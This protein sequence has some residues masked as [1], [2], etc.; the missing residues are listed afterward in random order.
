ME[1]PLTQ[2]LMAEP[3][4]L[5][6]GAVLPNR[7]VKAA[8]SE[9]LAD[10]YNN[11]DERLIRLYTAW[12]HG[13]SG[14]ILSGNVMVDRDHVNR[15]GSMVI[16]GQ[17]DRESYIRLAEAGR[18]GGN[19]FW[20]QIVHNGR[21]T[22]SSINS[23]PLAPS[24]IP[25]DLGDHFC[26]P[27]AMTEEEILDAIARF[28][29]ASKVAKETGF[30]GVQLHGAHGYLVS[31]F[32]SP[33]TNK[34]TDRWGGSLENRSRFCIETLRAMRE[35]VGP[36]FP[37]AIKL[38][39]ADFQR[40]GF[41]HDES[42]AVVAML[43]EES[44][45]LLEIS[46]GT[47]EQMGMFGEDDEAAPVV[48]ESTREREAY[49]LE[50]AESIRKIATMPLMV[51]GGFRTRGGIEEALATGATDLIGLGRPVCVEPDL[52]ARLVDGT[53]DEAYDYERRLFA[54]IELIPKFDENGNPIPGLLTSLTWY[55]WQLY[56]L[57]EGLPADPDLPLLEGAMQAIAQDVQILQDWIEAN[58]ARGVIVGPRVAVEA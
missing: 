24:A 58:R 34:R 44:L 12:A 26:M 16:D 30:T 33:L 55:S 49:F 17:E 42:L 47:Y 37:L 54:E 21:Q 7:L 45:D 22:D 29:Y 56:L 25:V 27:R 35:A 19:E 6:G 52:P 1:K 53:V 41:T 36:S 50:Y 57:G 28:A 10:V 48:K 8:L 38:N 3:F 11:P 5:P 20:M 32:L 18:A 14:L 46:G 4:T 39:S 51:T 9:G 40:G 13:G 23:E 43:N 15:P 31:Q 2:N